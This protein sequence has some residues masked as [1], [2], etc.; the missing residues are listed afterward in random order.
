MMKKQYS[1]Q[2]KSN[3]EKA[4]SLL[5]D[6]NQLRGAEE[7]KSVPGRQSLSLTIMNSFAMLTK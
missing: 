6:E 1:V 4:Q 5:D 7:I 3:R 2:K